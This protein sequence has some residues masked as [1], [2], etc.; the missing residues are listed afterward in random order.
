MRTASGPRPQHCES[1]MSPES[2]RGAARNQQLFQ[3][4]GGTSPSRACAAARRQIKNLKSKILRDSVL[5]Y[6]Q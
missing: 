1:S 3:G 6:C 4:S 2:F 5:W